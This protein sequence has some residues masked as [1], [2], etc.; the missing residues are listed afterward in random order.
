MRVYQILAKVLGLRCTEWVNTRN[1]VNYPVLVKCELLRLHDG[2]H[3]VHIT[4]EKA[5]LTTTTYRWVGQ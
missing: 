3:E 4:N 2:P 5:P 1:D